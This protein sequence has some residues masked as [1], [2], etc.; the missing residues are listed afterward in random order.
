MAS[1]TKETLSANHVILIVSAIEDLQVA[2][3]VKIEGQHAPDMNISVIFEPLVHDSPVRAKL[4]L[5]GEGASEP[6]PVTDRA[7]IIGGCQTVFMEAR[8]ALVT[9]FEGIGLFVAVGEAAQA[10]RGQRVFG[11]FVLAD[12]LLADVLLQ[13]P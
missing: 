6:L 1:I 7:D 12:H 3:L 13:V 10:A 11:L 5:S 9:V 8:S 4:A 2:H